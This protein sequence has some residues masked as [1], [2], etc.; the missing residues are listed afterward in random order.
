M[1]P[2]IFTLL[3]LLETEQLVSPFALI[4][5]HRDFRKVMPSRPMWYIVSPVVVFVVAV[6]FALTSAWRL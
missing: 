5:L 6:A 1:D 4:W 2:R 3:I